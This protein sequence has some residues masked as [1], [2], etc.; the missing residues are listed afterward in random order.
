M[1]T[2]D[3]SHDSGLMPPGAV[4]GTTI[5][6]MMCESIAGIRGS[7][8]ANSATASPVFRRFLVGGVFEG[9]SE[10]GAE[11]L[12]MAAVR[13]PDAPHGRGG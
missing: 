5:R 11:L 12:P 3:T 10:W 8:R 6:C 4:T 1:R 9:L 2:K 13:A 7:P